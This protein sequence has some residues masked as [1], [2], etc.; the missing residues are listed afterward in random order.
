MDCLTRAVMIGIVTIGWIL[1]MSISDISTKYIH[2]LLIDHSWMTA[3][4]VN[5]A[6]AKRDDGRVG[7]ALDTIVHEVF[8]H[9]EPR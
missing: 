4:W 3:S 2:I 1:R 7:T 6:W 8:V 5:E 9:H